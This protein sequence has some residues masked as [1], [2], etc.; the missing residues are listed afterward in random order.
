MYYRRWQ[1]ALVLFGSFRHFV[2]DLNRRHLYFVI[3][4]ILAYLDA[5]AQPSL[6]LWSETRPSL[7]KYFLPD[8]VRNISPL[9][10]WWTKSKILT[11][12]EKKNVSFCL[13]LFIFNAAT[14]VNS[15][16]I[17]RKDIEHKFNVY[18][19][20]FFQLIVVRINCWIC[21]VFFNHPILHML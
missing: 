19:E 5:G 21:T 8:D 7:H 1:K 3:P 2:S 15:L 12:K 13:S 14:I 10:I 6:N 4:D 17:P 9:L 11:R 16:R 18:L 20:F